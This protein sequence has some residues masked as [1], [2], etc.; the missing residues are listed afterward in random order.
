[1]AN[2]VAELTAEGELV[3]LKLL[4][5]LYLALIIALS[6]GATVLTAALL[7]AVDL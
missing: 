6:I 4:S 5:N 1:M 3:K 7:D 2:T